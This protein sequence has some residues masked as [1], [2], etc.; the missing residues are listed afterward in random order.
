MRAI[1]LARLD[2]VRPALMLTRGTALGYLT[3]VTVAPI[4]STTRGLTTEVRLGTR[5]GLDHDCVASC[6]NIMT[7]HKDSIVKE[8]G[9]LLDDQEEALT[10]AIACAFDLEGHFGQVAPP[11]PAR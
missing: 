3:N 5:N 7:V 1:V 10:Q 8:I 4:T 6:D 11:E 9:F 2:K